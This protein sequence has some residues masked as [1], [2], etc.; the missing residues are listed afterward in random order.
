M[1][2]QSV[3]VENPEWEVAKREYENLKSHA[4]SLQNN[5]DCTSLKLDRAW[6]DVRCAKSKL[7]N[8]PRYIHM[9]A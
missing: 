4:E 2:R 5:E 3:K 9:I 6:I 1:N 7:D 8:T